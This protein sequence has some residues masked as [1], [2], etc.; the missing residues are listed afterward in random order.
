[1]GKGIANVT[2]DNNR[3]PIATQGCRGIGPS[4]T[5][6]GRAYGLP[7][8]RVA[9]LPTPTELN[10]PAGPGP[11]RLNT[12]SALEA[13]LLTQQ[14]EVSAVALPRLHLQAG[15]LQSGWAIHGIEQQLT[16]DRD[17]DAICLDAGYAADACSTASHGIDFKTGASHLGSSAQQFCLGRSGVKHTKASGAKAQGGGR[18]EGQLIDLHKTSGSR[19]ADA[20]G[21]QKQQIARLGQPD[22]LVDVGAVG[23]GHPNNHIAEAVIVK[24]HTLNG[25]LGVEVGKTMELIRTRTG[26]ASD[27]TQTCR[28]TTAQHS[29]DRAAQTGRANCC[30]HLSTGSFG[31][32]QKWQG[33]QGQPKGCCRAP[34]TGQHGRGCHQ[35]RSPKPPDQRMT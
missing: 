27:D 22:H 33:H 3:A 25:P 26:A 2:P 16:I 15:I 29:I 6:K 11:S 20:T 21:R 13:H 24:A 7:H 32:T 34:M 5:T 19:H 12:G 9:V 18:T 23:A 35:G 10:G 1:M 8:G 14:T 30:R 4:L 17:A 28:A 31:S